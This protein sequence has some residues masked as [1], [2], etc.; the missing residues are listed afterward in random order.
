MYKEH[1][2]DKYGLKNF[3]KI[4]EELKKMEESDL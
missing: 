2:P 3:M 4:G 1:F